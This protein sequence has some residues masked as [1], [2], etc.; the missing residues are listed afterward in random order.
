MYSFSFKSYKWKRIEQKG[1]IPCPRSQHSAI[2]IGD[3]MYVYGGAGY[4][5]FEEDHYSSVYAFHLK[6]KKWE[7]LNGRG[8]C[9][10]ERSGHVVVAYGGK[11]YVMGGMSVSGFHNDIFEFD[12]SS[13]YWKKLLT[14]GPSPS[15]LSVFHS[16]VQEENSHLMYILGSLDDGDFNFYQFDFTKFQWSKVQ[17]KEQVPIPTSFHTCVINGKE[18]I[19][20]GGENYQSVNNDLWRII[21]PIPLYPN[22][23]EDVDDYF[24]EEVDSQEQPLQEKIISQM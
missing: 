11:M 16:A 12:T 7:K 17:F 3:R 2:V 15:L 1:D 9:P 18:I 24:L 19:L 5:P 13:G 23:R 4:Y 10:G 21:L 8:E 20:F 22:H 14:K 6:E